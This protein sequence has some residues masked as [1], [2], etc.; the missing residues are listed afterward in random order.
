MK[1]PRRKFMTAS[2]LPPALFAALFA[3][4]AMSALA[5]HVAPVAAVTAVDE[6]K[7]IAREG[8]TLTRTFEMV[9]EQESETTSDS[10]SFSVSG[11][12]ERE[13]VVIDVVQA[14]D[15][16][17]VLK[18]ER[19]YDTISNEMAQSMES[20]SGGSREMTSSG[21][22]ELEGYSVLFEWDED[23][24]EY[25]VSSEDVD[26]D[27]LEDLIYDYDFAVFLP[28]GDVSE[29]DEWEI[30]I[31]A[32]QKI[33]K[34]WDGLPIDME[35][36][37]GG[38]TRAADDGQE[39]EIEKSVDGELT[40]TYMGTREEDGVTVA[41]IELEGEIEA[42]QS[43][44][45]TSDFEGGSMEFES[46]STEESAIQ[47]EVLWNIAGGHLHSLKIEI[48]TESSSTQHSL[49]IFGDQ[50]FENDAEVEGTMTATLTVTVE[51]T[52]E[53]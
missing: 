24:E 35:S 42:E 44:S 16:D 34:P 32:F 22:S 43:M 53:D 1:H 48:E 17:R 30:D 26:D 33:T 20:D 4:L 23:D 2:L 36:G 7:L 10:A 27:L 11:T 39:P 3:A 18:L 46:E 13:L 25:I 31:E 14:V 19:T 52:E 45:G 28:D 50:E 12:I 38:A 15:D 49:T 8:L 9:G 41:V 51:E 40:A 47:G 29:G 21:S 37:V 6:I 5:R